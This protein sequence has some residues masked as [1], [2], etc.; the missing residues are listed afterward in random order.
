MGC[1]R[2]KIPHVYTSCWSTFVR[3]NARL[4]LLYQ[5][6]LSFVAAV[7]NFE[8]MDEASTT[9]AAEAA[10]KKL[11]WAASTAKQ[12]MAQDMM[13][14]LVPYKTE[15]KNKEKLYNDMY[16]GTPE[17]EDWPWD[18]GKFYTRIRSLQ[19]TIRKMMQC[20]SIDEAAFKHDRVLH[21][22]PNTP[23][24]PTH[25]P[26]GDR[27]WSGSE[28]ATK[29]KEDFDNK[30][31]V[32]LT[33]AEFKASR[34]C[35]KDFDETRITQRLDYLRQNEKPFGKTPGQDKKKKKAKRPKLPQYK[36]ENSRTAEKDAY[37]DGPP[38]P[39]KKRK[40]D[41]SKKKK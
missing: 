4:T 6:G 27:L 25:Y 13:D 8:S 3:S 20:K 7:I 31:H 32:N 30:R 11:D 21:P 28:A 14:G 36:P 24:G 37:V 29:L 39:R 2:E 5:S 34:D 40:A 10:A 16:A 15:I 12:L 1:A 18:A 9:K 41:N 17:F 33:R 35:Y 19:A 38:P 26:N 22:A 23:G